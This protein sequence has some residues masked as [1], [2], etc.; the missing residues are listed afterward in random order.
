MTKNG[1]AEFE[2]RLYEK[3]RRLEGMVRVGVVSDVN[4]DEG[5]ARVIFPS[6]NNLVSAELLVLRQ[7]PL[8][9]VEK[10]SD[11]QKW[12]YDAEY[13]TYDRG[14]GLGETYD[15]SF[16]DVINNEITLEY[17][18]PEHGVDE[19]KT[20]REKITV[21]PWMPFIDQSVLC[22]YIPLGKY[23]GFILGGLNG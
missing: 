15:K 14:I 10:F 4:V 3:I 23:D 5:R 13:A 17:R 16:P 7:I 21:R 22:L 20:H 1:N 2:R 9:T 11:G 19:T 6:S 12:K 8:V 18:C